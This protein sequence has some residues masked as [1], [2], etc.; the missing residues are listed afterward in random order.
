M[1]ITHYCSDKKFL[2]NKI[3][4]YNQEQLK[5]VAGELCKYNGCA[6]ER[7]KNFETYYPQR[8]ITEKWLYVEAKKK[9]IMP[10]TNSPWYFVLGHSEILSTGFGNFAFKYQL[11]LE[12]ISIKHI[13]FT[14][15]DSMG[16]F[17]LPDV[18]R[19]VYNKDE[20]I[21]MYKSNDLKNIDTFNLL[22][23]K[24]K[25]IEA[26]LWTDQYFF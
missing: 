12:E 17:K 16:V 24:H 10:E 15:G 9:G 22:Q 18:Y 7:F 5:E 20:I 8:L 13:S 26:Q 14:L 6:Y 23:E 19:N 11:C 21:C 3:T 25:Y 2:L 1:Y 4:E